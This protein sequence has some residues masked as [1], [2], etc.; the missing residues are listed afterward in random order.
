M[1]AAT[2]YR[3][4]K[5][6][7]ADFHECDMNLF[8]IFHLDLQNMS[9]LGKISEKKQKKRE[10]YLGRAEKRAER[11]VASI[12]QKF[13]WAEQKNLKYFGFFFRWP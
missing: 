3:S 2:Y 5:H 13:D 12:K 4:F 8:R 1:W 9:A 7:L 10:P 11:P 6:V